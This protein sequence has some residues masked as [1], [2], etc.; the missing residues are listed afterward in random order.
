MEMELPFLELELPSLE[1]EL[2][3]LEMERSSLEMGLP[4]REMEGSFHEMNRSLC[5]LSGRWGSET[6]FS[7]LRTQE[8]MKAHALLGDAPQ[9]AHNTP[10]L[11]PTSSIRA[12]RH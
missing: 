3:F 6:A 5:L 9:I 10:G 4:I 8:R 1:L 7:T 12:W 2:P 11:L